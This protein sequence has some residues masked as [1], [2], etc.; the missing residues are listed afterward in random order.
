[1]HKVGSDHYHI[2]VSCGAFEREGKF[3]VQRRPADSQFFPNHWEFPGGK[4]EAN[5]QHMVVALFREWEEELGVKVT[6]GGPLAACYNL[7]LEESGP[8]ITADV[9]MFV[10]ETTNVEPEPLEGQEIAWLTLAEIEKLPLSPAMGAFV[11]RLKM[12]CG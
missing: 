2:Q 5:E 1:M 3:L 4:V 9:F 11:E 6:A 8:K 12:P 7:M 10:V